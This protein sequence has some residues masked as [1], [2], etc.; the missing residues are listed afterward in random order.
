MAGLSTSVRATASKRSLATG[1]R[2]AGPGMSGYGLFLVFAVPWALFTLYPIV[3]S[4]ILSLEN[5]SGLGGSSFVGLNNYQTLLHD[6]MWWSAVA[7]TLLFAAVV[8]IGRTVLAVG[9]GVALV[10]CGSG[11]FTALARAVLFWP[12]V[13]SVSIV[14]I[15]WGWLANP[16]FGTLTDVVRAVGGPDINWLGP[17]GA[18]WLLVIIKIW[19]WLGFSVLLVHA[20]MIQ[21]PH[22]LYEAAETDGAGAWRQF[23]SITLPFIMPQVEFL[24]VIGIA[25]EMQVFALPQIL[26]G[27]GPSYA[28]Y[29]ALEDFYVTAFQN[30]RLGY[31]SS[32]AMCLCVIS[33]ALA[34][35]ARRVARHTNAFDQS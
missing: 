5:A 20:G 16:Q 32:M 22:M 1:H 27:G 26:T 35:I 13:L 24:I 15:I 33:V 7:R 18:F 2:Q 8:V 19:W 31:A 30:L 29:M 3:K 17:T 9:L 34:L 28:T 10:K 14:T 21:V 12:Y 6:G 4:V 11:R 23:R 25:Q